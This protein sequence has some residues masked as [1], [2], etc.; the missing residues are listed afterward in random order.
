MGGVI[1]L[2]VPYKDKEEVKSSGA[3]WNAHKKR[4]YIRPGL[5]I[6][7][8]KKW[9]PKTEDDCHLRARAP[10]YLVETSEICWVCDRVTPVITL[11]SHGI[12]DKT[13]DWSLNEFCTFEYIQFIP[14]KLEKFLRKRFPNYFKDFSKT[15]NSYYYMNHCSCGV[16][17]GDFYLHSEPGAAFCPV[18]EEACQCIF[19]TELK[20]EGDMPVLASYAVSSNDLIFHHANRKPLS[21]LINHKVNHT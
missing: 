5:S 18:T 14:P 3:R 2:E 4:W 1:F 20:H 10:I 7:P 11:A 16:I 17:L 6:A 12:E 21:H 19:L 15:T 13:K 8:F 9:L